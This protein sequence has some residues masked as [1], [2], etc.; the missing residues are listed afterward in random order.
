M[1]A[2]GAL[3]PKTPTQR[4][5]YVA[6]SVFTDRAN[7]AESSRQLQVQ[8]KRRQQRILVLKAYFTVCYTLLDPTA[9]LLLVTQI[10][11]P[12]KACSNA[13]RR[14]SSAMQPQAQEVALKYVTS[15]VVSPSLS[16]HLPA[17]PQ[18]KGNQRGDDIF[19]VLSVV[20]NPHGIGLG[21]E[22]CDSYFVSISLATVLC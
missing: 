10:E 8:L 3:F 20:I 21:D 2:G 7:I 22:V 9:Y 18:S 14:G 11:K 4:D 6:L 1:S 12:M 13:S 5:H 19:R 15:L 16:S 17:Q